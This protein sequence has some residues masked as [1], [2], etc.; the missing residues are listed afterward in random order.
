MYCANCGSVVE[1]R[2]KF[3]KM[4]GAPVN[5]NADAA[6]S[7]VQPV[8]STPV[9]TKAQAGATVQ[10][11][12]KGV[13][14]APLYVVGLI[15]DILNLLLGTGMFIIG[16]FAYAI[17]MATGSAGNA[18]IGFIGTLLS[19]FAAGGAF[20]AIIMGIINRSK[21]KNGVSSDKTRSYVTFII[22]TIVSCIM[23]IIGAYFIGTIME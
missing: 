12:N 15:F 22:L 8:P 9:Q 13:L 1:G 20:I 5:G 17:E 18:V 10:V 11:K 14:P 19:G 3:C 16:I 2:S 6:A 23:F 4:C 7:S 21:P